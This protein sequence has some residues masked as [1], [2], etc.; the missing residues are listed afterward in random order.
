[1]SLF[2]RLA[3]GFVLL[4]G[5]CGGVAS[6]SAWHQT[7]DTVNELFDT[8]QMLFAKRLLSLDPTSLHAAS[9][10][11]TKSILRH[12]RGDQD[13]DALAFAIFRA[14]GQPLLNDGE[15]GRDIQFEDKRDGFRDGRLRGDDD[16]WRLLWLTSADKQYRVVVGQEWEYRDDMTRDLAL[17]SLMPWLY[18][19][20]FMLLMLLALV[21]FELRP[22]K[23]LTA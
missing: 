1:M 21:W 13:D 15:N 17:A 9:L 20:P 12:H 23:R 4:I 18:A 8:Q 5:L 16:S 22:L 6:Y 14:D 19:M 2:L 7:R 10:P 11:K 3:I